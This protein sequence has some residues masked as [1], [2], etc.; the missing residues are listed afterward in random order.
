MPQLH[1]YV[2]EDVAADITRRAK[3]SGL[4]VSRFLARL[5]R[6]RT[7]KGWPEGWFDRVPG[8]WQGDPLERPAQGEFEPRERLR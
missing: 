4:S 1:L 3:E 5:V 7:S 6:R 2:S 8:G